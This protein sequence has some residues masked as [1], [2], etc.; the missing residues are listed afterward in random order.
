M[1]WVQNGIAFFHTGNQYCGIPT[2][3][4]IHWSPPVAGSTSLTHTGRRRMS[5]SCCAN[6]S[7]SW[8]VVSGHFFQQKYTFFSTWEHNR[9][10]NVMS[11]REVDS[12]KSWVIGN[13]SVAQVAGSFFVM[14]RPQKWGWFT[15]WAMHFQETFSYIMVKSSQA[16]SIRL[17]PTM[18]SHFV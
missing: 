17:Y 1:P 11:R 6:M 10:G 15:R 3:V 13:L 14:H 2:E 9:T 12:P 5:S 8:K 4:F 18:K 16:A 7:G